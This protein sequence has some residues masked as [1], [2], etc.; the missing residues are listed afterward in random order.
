MSIPLATPRK[1]APL[2]AA[3]EQSARKTNSQ[4]YLSAFQLWQ[5]LA[6]RQTGERA[7]GESL[8]LQAVA[9]MDRLMQ[10]PPTYW[11]HTLAAWAVL[12]G[13]WPATLAI[14]DRELA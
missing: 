13:D 6:A 11:F 14:R 5:G 8:R 4:D 10:P 7:K 2:S 9:R 1:S 3:G 12:E